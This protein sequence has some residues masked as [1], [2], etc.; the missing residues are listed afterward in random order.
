PEDEEHKEVHQR[1][2]GNEAVVRESSEYNFAYQIVIW[3]HKA[4]CET[5]CE[6]VLREVSI[7]GHQSDQRDDANCEEIV[8]S[9]KE[10]AAENDQSDRIDEIARN[11]TRCEHQPAE[12]SEGD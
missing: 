6:R 12:H 1:S 10:G 5:V 7:C 11:Q 3:V 8:E 9:T 4:G 2:R